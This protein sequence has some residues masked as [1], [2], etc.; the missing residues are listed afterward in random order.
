MKIFQNLWNTV[1]TILRG[2]VIKI[3]TYIKKKDLQMNNLTLHI[4][5]LKEKD[6]LSQKLTEEGKTNKD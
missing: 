6:N 2:K 1:K 5:E 4:K 3:I